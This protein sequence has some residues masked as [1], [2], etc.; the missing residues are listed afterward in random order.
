MITCKYKWQISGGACNPSPSP[1]VYRLT[2]VSSAR[3]STLTADFFTSRE[4]IK[5]SIPVFLRS[6]DGRSDGNHDVMALEDIIKNFLIKIL[7]M[8]AAFEF[9]CF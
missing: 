9:S 6:N 2:I 1:L 8:R 7:N 4:L 3:L 5:F